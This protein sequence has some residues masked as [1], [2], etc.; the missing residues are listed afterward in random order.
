MKDYSIVSK[1][2]VAKFFYKSI[3]HKSPIRRTI[4][5][6]QATATHIVGY[7]LREGHIVRSFKKAPIKTYLRSKIAKIKNIDKRISLR[8]NINSEEELNKSTYSRTT[9]IELFKNGI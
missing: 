3:H 7:E 4:L 5:I 8:K 1:N 2:P 6:I 9:L